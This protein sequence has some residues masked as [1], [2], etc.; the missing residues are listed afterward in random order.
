[1]RFM[2]GCE[3]RIIPRKEYLIF[4]IPFNQLQRISLLKIAFFVRRVTNVYF[5]FKIY[6]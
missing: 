5:S 1:V 2:K 3:H 6:K 4:G